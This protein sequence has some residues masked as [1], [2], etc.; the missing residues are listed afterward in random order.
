M[1]MSYRSALGV[2]AGVAGALFLGYCLYFDHRRRSDPDFKKKLRERRECVYV[3]VYV[4]VQL[5]P[6]YH[7][8]APCVLPRRGKRGEGWG[9]RGYV[10]SGVGAGPDSSPGVCA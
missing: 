6:V 10:M 8:E 1:A 4:P 7:L 3:R 5:C 2:C 9:E